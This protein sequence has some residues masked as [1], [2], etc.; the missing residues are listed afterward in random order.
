MIYDL[1][2]LDNELVEPINLI[3]AKS[4]LQIDADYATDDH[5]ISLA[6]STARIRLEQYLNVGLVNRDVSVQWNGELLNLPL[7]PNLNV[8]EVTKNDEIT[9]LDADLY[10]VSKMRAKKI[11][12]K[13]IYG[14]TGDWFYSI[15]NQT[16]YFTPTK[17]IDNDIYTVKYNTGYEDLPLGLRQALLAE[18]SYIFNL[19]GSPITDVISPNAALLASCYSRNLVL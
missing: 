17:C 4:A 14:L 3:E 10:E 16:A 2:E 8:L 6:I 11:A 1:I 5:I 13:S 7:Y 9:P 18:M 12:I 15:T 19:H